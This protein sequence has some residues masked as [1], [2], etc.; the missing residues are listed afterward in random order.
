MMQ[1]TFKNTETLLYGYSST[2]K[3]TKSLHSCALDKSSLSMER[4]NVKPF[5]RRGFRLNVSLRYLEETPG[6]E[7]QFE[8]YL[9]DNC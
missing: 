1:K 2:G 9:Q 5:M 4:V 7:V 6:N 8:K 3:C